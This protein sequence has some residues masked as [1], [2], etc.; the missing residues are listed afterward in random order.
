M[1]QIKTWLVPL[2]ENI[3][4]TWVIGSTELTYVWDIADNISRMIGISKAPKD[5]ILNTNYIYWTTWNKVSYQI[6]T[7]LE[8]QTAGSPA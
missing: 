3:T 7:I 4:W 2:P 6:A 5:P 8:N 1:F